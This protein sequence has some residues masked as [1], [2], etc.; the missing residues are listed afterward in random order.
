M[1]KIDE[2]AE[3]G[4]IGGSGFYSL[5]KDIKKVVVNTPFGAPSSHY[6]LGKVG[7]KKVAFLPRHGE[8]HQFPPHKIPFKANIYG[9]KKLGIKYLISPCAAGSLQTHI[10]PGDFVI[11][12]QFV[13]RTKGR[14]DTFF[15]GPKVVHITCDQPYCQTLRSLATKV[16][17]KLKYPVHKTGTVVV[18]NGPRF[19]TLAESEWFKNQGWEVINMTQYPEMVLA[20]E[21]EICFLN[22]SLITDYDVGVKEDEGVKPVTTNEVLRSFKK[23]NKKL[24][25]YILEIIKDIKL[26]KTCS[27]QSAL[28]QAIL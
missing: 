20:R 16:G 6:S 5:L 28:Q 17:H 15:E 4:V 25:K 19:S 1:I 18:I 27:C 2:Q 13:D 3:I 26:K 14:S 12:D 21:M 10:K 9:F 22:I 7:D 23:N 11:A 24:K 8:N